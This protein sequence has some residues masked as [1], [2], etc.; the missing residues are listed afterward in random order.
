MKK[1]AILAAVLMCLASMWSATA[2]AAFIY[3]TDWTSQ[4]AG[5]PGSAS[6]TILL[7]SAL[8]PSAI[9]VT[10][11]G[12]VS[13]DSHG[14]WQPASTFTKDGDVD[15]APS[16]NNNVT[17]NGTYS[18]L[19]TLSFSTPVI[20]PV[21]AILSLGGN[22][23]SAGMKFTYPFTILKYGPNYSYSES[24][25]T[26]TIDSSNILWGNGGNGIIQFSGTYSS[27]SWYA[28]NAEYWYMFTV[29]APAAVPLPPSVFL[30]GSALAGLGLLHRKCS[31]KKVSRT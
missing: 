16:G 17:L 4:T 15:N 20:N 31:L 19:Y 11:S 22:P 7:P 21:M 18:G 5:N 10:Y 6:G 29:G 25:G 13:N 8:L 9:T 26:L 2:Q 3:W 30:L 24:P 1:L 28:V 14:S 23:G 27:L 12:D